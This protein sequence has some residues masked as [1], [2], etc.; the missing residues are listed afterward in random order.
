RSG[1]RRV[2]RAPSTRRTDTTQSDVETAPRPPCRPGRRLPEPE[3]VGAPGSVTRRGQGGNE[4][5]D[6]R[7]FLDFSRESGVAADSRP[8]RTKAGD[9]PARIVA[10]RAAPPR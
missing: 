3:A 7:R 10:E 4:A 1:R 5:V 8:G 6:R 9:V 2:Q